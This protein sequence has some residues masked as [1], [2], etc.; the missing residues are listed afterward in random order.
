MDR[1]D[2]GKSINKRIIKYIVFIQK[3]NPPIDNIYVTL[4]LRILISE[5]VCAF[6]YVKCLAS[7]LSIHIVILLLFFC[8]QKIKLFCFQCI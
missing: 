7:L 3:K 6:V 2:T 1:G 5:N 8:K 4:F